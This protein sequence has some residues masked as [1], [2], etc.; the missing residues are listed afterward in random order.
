M[1]LVGMLGDNVGRSDYD[2]QALLETMYV[3]SQAD[4]MLE[5]GFMQDAIG[6]ASSNKSGHAM[7]GNL[8]QC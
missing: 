5:V 3:R 7:F 6:S 1:L 2:A 4:E 8:F